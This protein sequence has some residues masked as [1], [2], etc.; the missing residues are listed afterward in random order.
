MEIAGEQILLKGHQS[1]D[2]TKGNW[3]HKA[4]TS[5]DPRNNSLADG[6]NKYRYKSPFSITDT[7]YTL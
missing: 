1:Y 3:G 2:D 4:V 6:K 7:K 5:H